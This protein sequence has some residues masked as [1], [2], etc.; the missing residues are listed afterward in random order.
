MKNRVKIPLFLV[1]TALTLLLTACATKEPQKEG[2]SAATDY[3]TE[4]NA[5][6][7]TYKNQSIEAIE[8]AWVSSVIP[9]T[10]IEYIRRSPAVGFYTAFLANGNIIYVNPSQRLLFFGEIYT[11]TGENL[12][13]AAKDS[14]SKTQTNRS[15]D[16]INVTE[17]ETLGFGE[18][19]VKSEKLIVMV[20]SPLC[21]YCHKADKFFQ[22]SKIAIKR[23]FLINLSSP[24]NEDYKRAIEL[25]TSE[26]G[27]R[28]EIIE[29]WRTS[30]YVAPLKKEQINEE[31]AVN[32]TLLK[33]RH[34]ADRKKIDGTPY[35][36]LVNRKTN[37][38]E[39]LITGFGDD[40]GVE[41]AN[42]LKG[43]K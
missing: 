43:Q 25:M 31:E 12:T 40:T 22:D 35:I 4:S 39:R 18:V 32:Q 9:N 5:E 30:G 33:M 14:F 19:D 24:A 36:Y 28:D 2:V 38:V 10:K 34:F 11:S 15:I 26:K 29:R 1:L 23:I 27:K 6:S 8:A 21:P 42:W 7:E 3:K 13:N 16:E 41:I 20:T 37:K 17:L